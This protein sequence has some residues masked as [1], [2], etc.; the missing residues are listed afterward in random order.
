MNF[1]IKAILEKNSVIASRS[2]YTFTELRMELESNCR[3]IIW[4]IENISKDLIKLQN[5]K[6]P[7]ISEEFRIRA[8]SNLTKWSVGRFVIKK[9]MI[10]LPSYLLFFI[11]KLESYFVKFAKNVRMHFR[12]QKVWSSS[13]N[14][15]L[16]A[17]LEKSESFLLQPKD[18]V[19]GIWRCPLEEDVTDLFTPQSKFSNHQVTFKV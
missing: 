5:S 1:L 15:I 14:F 19:T 11:R 17:S 6:N 13:E 7:I 18:F 4:E 3:T 2:N 12:L 10:I 8:G 9:I 16:R